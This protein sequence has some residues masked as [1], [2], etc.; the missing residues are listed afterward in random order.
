MIKNIILV[1]I[2][3]ALGSVL[4]YLFTLVTIP[5][6]SKI[7]VNTLITNVLGCFFIGFLSIFLLN[8]Y[9]NA[10]LNVLFITGFCGGFTTFS[11]FALENQK[12]MQINQYSDSF[13][14]IILS[15]VCAIIA[16]LV[17]QRVGELFL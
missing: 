14:Y 16:V 7:Y 6:T 13:I 11:T 3:G 9:N 10:Q 2:G 15:V 4:R 5:F 12:M 17:G 8:K 1:A